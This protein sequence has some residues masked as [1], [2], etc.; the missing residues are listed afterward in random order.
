MNKFE[1]ENFHRDISDNDLVVDLVDVA[2]ILKKP[3][4]TFR[5]YNQFG[6]YSSSTICARFGSWNSALGKASLEQTIKR[7]IS[8]EELF[9]NLSNVWVS[10][11]KQPRTRD[12]QNNPSKYSFQT[13]SS[14]Y[15]SWRSSLEEFV[16]WANEKELYISKTKGTKKHVSTPRQ[17]SLRLRFKVLKR[18]DF[19]CCA[20][21]A[22]PS[23]QSGLVLHVDHIL[24]WSKG[25]L[26]DEKNLQTLCEPCNLGKS[27]VF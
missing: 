27:N 26:T 12:M 8:E 18:D 25:G 1:L 19:T 10:L 4:V 15:G 21:G 24:A 3:T 7:N 22:S 20:C 23:L 5:E 2:K 14:R 11:G 9:E 16:K 6:K 17:P 13:Y